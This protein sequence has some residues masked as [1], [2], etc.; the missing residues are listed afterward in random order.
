MA[1]ELKS[2]ADYL[3]ECLA[4]VAA[5]KREPA[6][7]SDLREK[8][9]TSS[10]E[11]GLPTR[12]MESWKYSPIAALTAS[13]LR[14][15]DPDETEIDIAP[16]L[17]QGLS[18]H[19]LVFIDG[20]YSAALSDP[21]DLPQ[22]LNLGSLADAVQTDGAR[23]AERLTRLAAIDGQPYVAMNSACWEDGLYL[24]LDKGV[25]LDR[26]VRMLSIATGGAVQTRALV[27]VEAGAELC[28]I[29]ESV[30]LQGSAHPYASTVSELF[31]GKD[32]RVDH[33]KIQTG[34]EKGF[35]IGHAAAR[36]DSGSRLRSR[37]I[38]WD[39]EF[40]RRE[41]YVE[42]A[43]A[44]A[45]LD[46]GLLYLAADGQTMD[47]RSRIIHAVPGCESTILAKGIL[48][49]KS[50][51]IF[52]GQIVVAKGSG[53]TLANQTNRNLLLGDEAIANSIPRLEIYAD[54]V[55]CSHGSTTGRLQEEQLYYLRTR[56]IP[57]DEAKAM[58][59]TA[60][61]RELIEAIEPGALRGSLESELLRRLPGGDESEDNA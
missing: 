18:E 61:A 47:M 26:P 21:G 50:R 3:S 4:A 15:S 10:R 35:H 59:I 42:M 44:G 27:I 12:G 14:R 48:A 43:G 31:C 25:K 56:G 28:L 46:H 23:I 39:G 13:P 19:R 51:G 52:D 40:T 16:W 38:S 36:L 17:I 49:G 37:E 33:I 7:L 41:S 53:Q 11:Q 9:A 58:L 29:E 6:W 30:A 8:A 20:R 5:P 22:G 24:H 55:K 1:T 2:T 57:A 34:S 60:F 32:A 54:D 45:D